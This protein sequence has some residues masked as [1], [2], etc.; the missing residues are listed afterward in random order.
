[1]AAEKKASEKK[2]AKKS[3]GSD[4]KKS[5]KAKATTKVSKSRKLNVGNMPYTLSVPQGG[6]VIQE[7]NLMP[8]LPV[9]GQAANW[10][11]FVPND[12]GQQ[13][14]D[15]VIVE[16]SGDSTALERE[17][18]RAVIVVNIVQNPNET[19][20]SW[21][22]AL[23]GVAPDSP[24]TDPNQDVSV[25]IT[26]GGFTL[27]AYVHVYEDSSELIQFG[28]VASFTDL[29]SGVVS[30]YESSDPGIIPKRP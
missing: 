15:S 9:S 5:G 8:S 29:T 14:I 30:I 1:M 4:K 3:A 16:F 7:F 22:F 20:G 12:P 11:L 10:N 19:Q 17:F 27:I 18:E 25:E 24:N 6:Q 21:R 23:N 13:D 28:Y 26:N 2:V